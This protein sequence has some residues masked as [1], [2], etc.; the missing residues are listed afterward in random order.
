M[1]DQGGSDF[2][3]LYPDALP[4]ADKIR[5]IATEIYRAADVTFLPEVRSAAG[6]F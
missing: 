5:M 2:R 6:R 3:P 1:I 4:L